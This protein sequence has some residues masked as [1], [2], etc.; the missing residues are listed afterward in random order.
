MKRQINRLQ[1]LVLHLPNIVH[2]EGQGLGEEEFA[3]VVRH[4]KGNGYSKI[5][6][7]FYRVVA[8]TKGVVE[9]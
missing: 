6:S 5:P 3:F 2:A 4:L 8:L 7:H 1:V 9:A